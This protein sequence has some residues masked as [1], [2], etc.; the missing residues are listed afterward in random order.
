MS[1][2]KTT[3][4]ALSVL[5]LAAGPTGA[6]EYGIPVTTEQAKKIAAGVIPECAGNKWNVAVAVIGGVGVSG[7]T[8]DQDEQCAKEGLG[9]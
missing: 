8:R 6:A 9:S 5:T 2:A 3:L 7:V 1:K 4:F